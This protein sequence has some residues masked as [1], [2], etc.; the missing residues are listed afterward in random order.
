MGTE[1]LVSMAITRVPQG[2][3]YGDFIKV[4]SKLTVKTKLVDMAP[5][6][7]ITLRVIFSSYHKLFFEIFVTKF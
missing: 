7:C 5:T 2:M 4:V 6:L 1:Y 3:G